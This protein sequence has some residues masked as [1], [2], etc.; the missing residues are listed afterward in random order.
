[1]SI[2]D[3]SV[4]NVDGEAF[5]LEQFQGKARFPALITLLSHSHPHT[6]LHL[7]I[8]HPFL[9]PQVTLIVNVASQ[10]GFTP[11]VRLLRF[12]DLLPPYRCIFLRPSA[13]LAILTHL[14]PPQYAGLR[15]LHGKFE[16]QGFSVLAFPC[17]QFGGQE[18]D[19][20]PRIKSFATEKYQAQFPIMD[21]IEVNG[22][23]TSP[24]Y[25]AIKTV[26]PGNIKWNFE[27]VC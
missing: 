15:E 20:C 2:Y 14:S 3:L 19:V 12:R 10:C 7:A 24:V 8:A 5:A 21:K 25:A 1:M 18:P 9:R 26:I 13:T 6:N 4:T 16:E 22:E 17:N 27:K 23:N 11:Q